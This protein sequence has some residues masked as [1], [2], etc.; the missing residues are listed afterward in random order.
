MKPEQ[1]DS[2]KNPWLEGA[3]KLQESLKKQPP[4]VQQ[5]MKEM[6]K[7]QYPRN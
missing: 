4:E 5:S 1:Q 7:K 2:D 3:R 6:S